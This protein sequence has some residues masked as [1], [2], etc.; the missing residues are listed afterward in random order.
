M[1]KTTKHIYQIKVALQGAKPP[2][3]R[4]LLIEGSVKL[5][6]FHEVLQI[7][8]GWTDSHLHQFQAGGR[9]FGV[10][11][12]DWGLDEVEDERRF[13]LD[14]VLMREKDWLIYDYDF[15]DGWSHKVTLEKILPFDPK[16][17]LPV[18]AKAKRACPPEDV[19][20]IWGYAHFLEA[21]ADPKHEEH[22]E[23]LEWVGG[24]F[25]PEAYDL[26]E[27]NAILEGRGSA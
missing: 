27:V 1:A 16:V 21:I 22:D 7:V 5:S 20:G 2:I 19:G 25:D 11:D 14:Q 9:T 26:D 8:M 6:R 17:R 24:D 12:P 10:P 13:R 4:R 15:G 23:L 18:C 3:W